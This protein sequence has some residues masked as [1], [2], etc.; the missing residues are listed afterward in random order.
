MSSWSIFGGA[1]QRCLIIMPRNRNGRQNRNTTRVVVQS[2]SGNQQAAQTPRTRRARRP[3][4]NVNVNTRPQPTQKQRPSVGMRMRP[5]GRGRR[6][7]QGQGQHQIHQTITTTLGTVGSNTSGGVEN[8]MTIIINPATMK[9][10]TGS[11]S[12]GP[13]NVLASQ[14]AMWRVN[15]I[16]VR[17]KQLIGNNAA[18]GTVAR[19]SAVPNTAASQVSWSSL[20]AR[21]H[22]DADIG[23]NSTFVITAKELRGPKDGWYYTNTNL[24][25]CDSCAGLIQIHTLGRTMNP[26]QNQPYTGPLFLAEISTHWSFKNYQQNPGML[27]MVKSETTQNATI[28]VEPN[29]QKILM[30]VANSS[31]FGSIG[32]NPSAAEVIWM[33]TDTV[34]STGADVFPP[35][36]NWLF[37]G[38][39]WIVKRLANAPVSSD[40]VSTYFEVFAS[41]A[42]AQNN[43][44]C[45]ATSTANGPVTIQQVDY[46]QI[47][48]A[49]MGTAGESLAVMA[50]EVSS[51]L[52][53]TKM[54]TIY[55]TDD[56]YSPSNPLFIM[57][58]NVTNPGQGIGVGPDGSRIFTWNLHHVELDGT[59][60][61]TSG[62][63]VVFRDSA[64]VTAGYAIAA[65]HV[66]L[67]GNG[68]NGANTA[69]DFRLTSIL[70]RATISRK[71]N[72]STG[73]FV[74]S[75]YNFNRNNPQFT[76]GSNTF[77]T[78]RL[79]I[80][81]GQYYVAQFV[82]VGGVR[83]TVQVL[84]VDVHEPV[85]GWNTSA[86]TYTLP[87]ASGDVNSGLPVGYSAALVFDLM[88]AAHDVYHDAVSEPMG[89]ADGSD[90]GV[91]SE[92]DFP[93]DPNDDTLYF[94]EPPEGVLQVEPEVQATYEMLLASGCSPRQ[95]KLAVNQIKP[96]KQYQDFVATYHDSLVDGLSPASA[97]AAAL[98]HL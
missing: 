70:F 98:G 37:K 71:Y 15:R 20:G 69:K 94:D 47:T 60:P 40:G 80:D 30:K 8:E 85:D 86:A 67:Q 78:V 54:E 74:E 50:R 2:T 88:P 65:K 34:I 79:R 38:G 22:A 82:C 23:K 18:S 55:T 51:R 28:E 95:A 62:P 68:P 75:N 12:F 26:Y 45:Y 61:S 36:F 57:K 35:P 53:V 49:N 72:F 17:L 7:Q 81:E 39:W 56:S 83:R 19:V 48:P 96:S 14:Y 10:Q 4:V 25:S 32:Q 59:P 11:T 87:P 6:R 21:S 92:D 27:N 77:N 43:K 31:R 76:T 13:L 89:L 29:T 66:Y 33:I 58:E 44:P 93:A 90:D 91:D 46:Q 64:I 24:D 73:P 41:V 52:V 84:G 63:Q 16:E 5:N 42:D 9:E 97:R 3:T 1:D